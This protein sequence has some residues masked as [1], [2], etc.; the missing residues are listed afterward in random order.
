MPVAR[1]ADPQAPSV[2]QSFYRPSDA[3]R[4]LGFCRSK[5]HKI[6]EQD[7]DFP[8]KIRL[9]SRCVGWRKQDLDAWLKVKAE[10]G[11]VI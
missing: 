2:E 4:Y 9:S 1:Q 8:R 7:P 6:A 5:L 10:R 3:C 11:G